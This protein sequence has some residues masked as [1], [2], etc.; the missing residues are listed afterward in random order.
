MGE[1]VNALASMVGSPAV[2]STGLSAVYDVKVEWT[3][4]PALLT[5]TDG[6]NTAEPGTFLF[7]A[8]NEQLGLR[9]QPQRMRV[10]IVIVDHMDRMPTHN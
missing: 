1:L 10:D 6:K 5:P 9:L 8:L 3:P 4:D 2:D 7:T